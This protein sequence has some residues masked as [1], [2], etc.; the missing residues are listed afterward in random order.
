MPPILNWKTQVENLTAVNEELVQS[1]EAL[2][3][4][5]NELQTSLGEL[6]GEF[7]QAYETVVELQDEVIDVAT[8]K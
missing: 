4:Q 6:V 7:N 8:R 2:T 1:N 3:N 5:T